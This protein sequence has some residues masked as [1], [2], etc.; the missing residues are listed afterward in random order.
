MKENKEKPKSL[1]NLAQFNNCKF[2]RNRSCRLDAFNCEPAN[3]RTMK[4][5]R[6]GSRIFLPKNKVSGDDMQNMRIMRSYDFA[7]QAIFLT[8]YIL[9]TLQC[10]PLCSYATA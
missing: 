3:H 8:S 4:K 6:G 10:F 2:V 7:Y 1:E 5:L 9:N